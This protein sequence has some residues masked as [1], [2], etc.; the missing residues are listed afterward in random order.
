M[1]IEIIKLIYSLRF[2]DRFNLELVYKYTFIVAYLSDTFDINP[3]EIKLLSTLT[4]TIILADQL[5]AILTQV[6]NSLGTALVEITL[7]TILI[8]IS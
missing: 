2:G 8:L 5:N 3:F 6:N 4:M 1:N 7:T